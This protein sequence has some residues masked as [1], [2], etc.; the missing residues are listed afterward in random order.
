MESSRPCRG[1]VHWEGVLFSWPQNSNVRKH[2]GPRDSKDV[3]DL[4]VH[5]VQPVQEGQGCSHLLSNFSD[6]KVLADSLSFEV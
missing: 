4:R 5:I 1:A 6:G 2:G 3:K